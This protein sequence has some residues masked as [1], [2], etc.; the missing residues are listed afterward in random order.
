MNLSVI[1]YPDSL[2]FA[3]GYAPYSFYLGGK[4]TYYGLPNNPDYDLGSLIGSPC[5]TLVGI[6]EAPSA[7]TAAEMFVYYAP[8]WQ[9]T[10]INA[11]QVAGSRYNLEVFDMMGKSVFRESGKLNPPYFTKNLNCSSFASGVYTVVLVTE[12]ERMIKRFMV[13]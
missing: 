3:C 10:F 6:N 1:N 4:R 5:D 7:N 8:G 12:R 13:E 9:T 2:G 11:Q